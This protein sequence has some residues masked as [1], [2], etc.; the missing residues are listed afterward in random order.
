MPTSFTSHG[1]WI[2]NSENLLFLRISQLH[3]QVTLTIADSY[4]KVI[5]RLIFK[6][7]DINIPAYIMFL[8]KGRL[9]AYIIKHVW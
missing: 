5:I 9:L 7:L 3:G 4:S 6:D 1:L 8:V 2:G